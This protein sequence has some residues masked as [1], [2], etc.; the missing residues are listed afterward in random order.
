MLGVHYSRWWDIFEYRMFHPGMFHPGMFRDLT[1]RD[2]TLCDGTPTVVN[3]SEITV[4][5]RKLWIVR[6]G[7]N[8]ESWGRV[9]S[10]IQKTQNVHNSLIS[11][12]YFSPENNITILNT[13]PIQ[14]I[15]ECF[16]WIGQGL[17]YNMTG[18]YLQIYSSSTQIQSWRYGGVCTYKYSVRRE[19]RVDMAGHLL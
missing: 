9:P 6:N 13:D 10:N 12:S 8:F 18:I 4:H 17:T 5:W 7:R 11:Q 15:D 16:F 14:V 19:N 1:S 3:G 2:W